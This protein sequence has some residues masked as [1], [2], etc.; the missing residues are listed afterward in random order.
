MDVVVVVFWRGGRH[1]VRCSA[2]GKTGWRGRRGVWHAQE[3]VNG[4]TFNSFD[5]T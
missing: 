3:A 1:P 5:A 4:A 2:G